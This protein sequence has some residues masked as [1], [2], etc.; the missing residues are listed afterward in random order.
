MIAYI[1]RFS[2]RTASDNK[3]AVS[4]AA[5]KVLEAEDRLARAINT[6]RCR[7][8]TVSDEQVCKWR[9]G[10]VRGH[11]SGGGIDDCVTEARRLGRAAG[12]LAT[13]ER[14][15]TSP[16]TLHIA[17]IGSYEAREALD[18]RGYSFDRNAHWWDMVGLRTS[19]G[20]WIEI[21]LSVSTPDRIVAEVEW[22]RGLG[23]EFAQ[24]DWLDSLAQQAARAV[25]GVKADGIPY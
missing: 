24:R 3:E 12:S 25:H 11:G 9:N 1:T 2:G 15:K 4:A 14:F 23:C 8:Y 22:L 5:A 21:D 16:P 20:W 6:A 10:D 18:K 7:G 17:V 13:A 19:A